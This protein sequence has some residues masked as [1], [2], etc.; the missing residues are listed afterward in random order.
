MVTLMSDIL[1]IFMID[2]YVDLNVKNFDNINIR[3]STNYKEITDLLLSEKLTDYLKDCEKNQMLTSQE[4]KSCLINCRII[5]VESCCK[6]LEK[7]DYDQKWLPLVQLFNPE[8]AL[9]EDF[10]ESHNSLIDIFD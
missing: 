1:K 5:L 3:D 8:N 9:S 6:L 4:V 7:F 10:H 2:D